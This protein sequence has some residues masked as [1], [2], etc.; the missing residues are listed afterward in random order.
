[1][2]CESASVGP[3]FQGGHDQRIAEVCAGVTLSMCCCVAA[4]CCC[5]TAAMVLSLQGVINV[6]HDASGGT[7]PIKIAGMA[8]LL[9]GWSHERFSAPDFMLDSTS[10][11]E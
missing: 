5:C 8:G 4:C 6:D 7:N 11:S 2:E 10:K 9:L 1:M 3:A